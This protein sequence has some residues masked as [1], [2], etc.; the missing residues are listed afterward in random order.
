MKIIFLS[1]QPLSIVPLSDEIPPWLFLKRYDHWSVLNKVAD[2]SIY[3]TF[4][5]LLAD[6][7][8]YTFKA[9]HESQEQNTC[10]A[11]VNDEFGAGANQ[12]TPNQTTNTQI[13]H[14]LTSSIPSSG[15]SY[16][17]QADG[18][19]NSLLASVCESSK[20]GATRLGATAALISLLQYI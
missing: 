9:G 13:K 8:T 2:A 16:D 20:V 17:R 15:C 6:L 14:V 5:M 11:Y 18:E 12:P 7:R 19:G 4:K 10:I 1:L 3:W